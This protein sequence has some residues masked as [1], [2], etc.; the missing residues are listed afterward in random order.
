[1]KH[2]TRKALALLQ[3]LALTSA[4]TAEAAPGHLSLSACYQIPGT[5]QWAI[6]FTV[7]GGDSWGPSEPPC[8]GRV[9]PGGHNMEPITIGNCRSHLGGVSGEPL[10][11]RILIIPSTSSAIGVYEVTV[12]GR[13]TSPNVSEPQGGGTVSCHIG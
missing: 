4:I 12:K 8:S 9:L 10:S 7:K 1:M 13:S 11:G 6:D 3:G 2:A 5:F